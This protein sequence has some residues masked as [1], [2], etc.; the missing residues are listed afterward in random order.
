[1]K[2]IRLH[3]NSPLAATSVP[4]YFIDEFMG[5]ANGEFVK[6]YL[7]LLRC[8][9]Y[10]ETF[11]ISD[12]A[13]KFEN[14]ERDIHRALAYW[15]KLHIL[16]L[17]Y[18][19]QGQLCGICFSDRYP[20]TG[21]DDTN[22]KKAIEKKESPASAS[23]EDVA[24][25][26]PSY[27]TDQLDSFSSKEDVSDLL[28]AAETYLGRTLNSTDM[29]TLLFWNDGL[30]FSI[31]LIEYLIEYCVDKGHRSIHYMDT[32]AM[33][34]ASNG[35]T[36]LEQAKWASGIHSQTS[37]AVMKAFGISGR[38]LAECELTYINTWTKKY[39]FALD[40]IGEACR[41]TIQATHQPSFEYAD[42]IL[43]NWHSQGVQHLEDIASLDEEHKRSKASNVAPDSS[44]AA[45]PAS[46]NKFTNYK[47]RSYDYNELEKKLLNHS[48]Q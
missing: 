1:M 30:H 6:I 15:E 37:Y 17:E 34:W 41:R 14:T 20:R 22:S 29:E 26:R 24:V 45:K 23:K 16:H 46:R 4:N 5:Q 40:I 19:E 10:G 35:Y 18:N 7:Y 3:T 47:Q 8:L 42:K 25:A 13:D 21:D 43:S 31:P 11:S 36:T 12:M 9:S 28:Y 33:S 39:N 44:K 48:V 27:T 32:V 2:D 38:S